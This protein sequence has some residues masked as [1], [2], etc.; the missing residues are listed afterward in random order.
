M[1]RIALFVMILAFIAGPVF[2]SEAEDNGPTLVFP[3][4]I[5]PIPHQANPAW[6]VEQL[7][8]LFIYPV[9][10]VTLERSA[11]SGS[12][13]YSKLDCNNKYSTYVLTNFH[14]IESA[15]AI[16]EEWDSS[17]KEM[18]KREKRSLVHVELFQY[19]NVSIPIGTLKVEAEIVIYNK[20]EDMALLKLRSETQA[21]YVAK[22]RAK[23]AADD[24]HV[25]EP[26][27]AVGCSLAFPPL[28]TNGIITRKNFQVDSLPFHMSSSQ[29]IYGNSGGAMFHEQ[30]GELIGIPSM[31]AVIGWGTPITH[32]GLFIPMARVYAWLEK[33][34][35]DFIF[36][37]EKDEE[38]CLLERK[39]EIEAKKK[40]KAGGS[41]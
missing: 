4:K 24:F 2:A 16:G 10:R 9:V 6:T 5:N 27:V 30:S 31:V 7:H 34:H 13:L 18:V 15:I 19:Q 21:P 41:L 35:Y 11:G 26:S 22:L 1:K 40:A 12:I 39:K 8:Q 38:T 25:M 23:D 3:V 37:P 20:S 17:L 33:E 28:P 32:M 36:D 14:V 29:I